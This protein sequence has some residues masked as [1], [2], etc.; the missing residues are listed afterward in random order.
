METVNDR[1]CWQLDAISV[2]VGLGFYLP[3]NI[4]AVD[5]IL[6][7]SFCDLSKTVLGIMLAH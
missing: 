6:I 4:P 7:G 2:V 5:V 3:F 1:G